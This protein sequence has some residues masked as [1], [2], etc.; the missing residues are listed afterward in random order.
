MGP[1]KA[2][3]FDELFPWVCV[4]LFVIT[5][6]G[7][8]FSVAFKIIPEQYYAKPWGENAV[9]TILG[10]EVDSIED[11]FIVLMIVTGLSFFS[12]FVAR[13]VAIWEWDLVNFSD[14]RRPPDHKTFSKFV[15]VNT[16]G[17]VFL[18]VT[19]ILNLFFSVTSIYYLMGATIGRIV[20]SWVLSRMKG[21]NE[22][23]P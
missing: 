15:L 10:I 4:I 21:T 7:V 16:G 14:K 22:D 23:S 2:N 18:S 19:S 13:A 11:F 20:S 12:S 6:S 8:S 3:N 1:R 5:V 9:T 17:A